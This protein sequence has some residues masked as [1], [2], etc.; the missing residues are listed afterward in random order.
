MA[1]RS[2]T[3]L[4]AARQ[5]LGAIALASLLLL[6]LAACA[7]NPPR[8]YKIALVAPFEGQARDV[9][10]G[11]FFA[12]RAAL[13]E[14]I[15]QHPQR[16]W[17][18]TFVAYNDNA[19][20]AFARRV[21]QNVVLD[22]DVL[23]V[24]GHFLP[25]TTAAALPVY[26][27]ANLPVLM[28]CEGGMMATEGAWCAM[29]DIR[30]TTQMALTAIEA[31]AGSGSFPHRMGIARALKAPLHSMHGAGGDSK[32]GPRTGCDGF[33]SVHPQRSGLLCPQAD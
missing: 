22:Q 5:A 17:Q 10:Y 32:L 28:R 9:G 3:Q 11:V 26:A 14:A 19:D 25:E 33:S 30:A 27:A 2:R 1:V 18:V 24:I 7:G 12:Y 20:P 31:S 21:A 8:T 16:N 29:G 13:Q 15:T 6:V 4:C 23:L